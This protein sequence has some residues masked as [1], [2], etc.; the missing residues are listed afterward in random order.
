MDGLDHEVERDCFLF[1]FVKLIQLMYFICRLGHI[2]CLL[3]HLREVVDN[4]SSAQ[5][6]GVWLATKHG[7]HS[8]KYA[9]GYK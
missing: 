6:P 7:T 1:F 2:F 9:R 8:T 3:F 5:R 4:T